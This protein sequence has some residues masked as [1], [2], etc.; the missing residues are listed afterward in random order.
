VSSTLRADA[1]RNRERIVAAARRCFAERGLEVGVDA[2][3]TEAGVGMGTLYRRFPT[4][5]S[6]IHA[7]FEQGL[8]ELQPAIDRA[9]AAEDAWE[10]F[11]ELV[12]AIV[13]QQASDQGF[14]QMVVLRLGPQ[15]IPEDVR[16]RVLAPLEELLARAQDAG[17][18]RDDISADD[19][20]A[21]IRMAG[22]SALGRDRPPDCRRHVGLLL[23]GLRKR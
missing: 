21:I 6:L 12:L 9:L 3:A 10:G 13:A 19:V 22:A 23:D 2:I 4:K 5:T 11:V 8:D 7:I 17:T 20:P 14:G 16:R 15:A 1:L 18:A